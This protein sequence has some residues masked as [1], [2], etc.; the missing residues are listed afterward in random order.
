MIYMHY[1]IIKYMYFI[2]MVLYI[3]IYVYLLLEPPSNIT[4]DEQLGHSVGNTYLPGL[5]GM[6]GG[7]LPVI[8]GMTSPALLTVTVSPNPIPS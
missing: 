8:L 6:A 5:P 7:I 3:N 2:T 1:N 4:G